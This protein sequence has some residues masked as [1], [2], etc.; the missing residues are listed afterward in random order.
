MPAKKKPRKPRTRR[1]P[2]KQRKAPVE[3]KSAQGMTPA[4]SPAAPDMA[5]TVTT[6]E[7]LLK[8]HREQL[9]QSIR[10]HDDTRDERDG[11]LA[12]IAITQRAGRFTRMASR[13]GED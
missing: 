10:E 1:K 6:Y 12:L 4:E 3:K 13:K 7:R 8:D 5:Q 11:L 2:N 9:M